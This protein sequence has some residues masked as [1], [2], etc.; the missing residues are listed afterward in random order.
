VT[1]T[2]YPNGQRKT[3]TD[4]T[5]TTSYTYDVVGNLFQKATPFGTINHGL[6]RYYGLGYGTGRL[7]EI[8]TSVNGGDR[9]DYGYDQLGRLNLVWDWN[10]RAPKSVSSPQNATLPRISFKIRE[11]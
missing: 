8:S 9:F 3:M 4:A 1:F 10:G 2:Y 11:K 6:D 7:A 5:G